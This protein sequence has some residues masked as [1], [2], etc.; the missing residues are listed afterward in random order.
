MIKNIAK[1]LTNVSNKFLNFREKY[2]IIFIENCSRL[3]QE[4]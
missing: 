4:I 2:R 1:D 3:I